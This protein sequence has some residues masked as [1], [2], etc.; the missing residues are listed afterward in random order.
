VS[1]AG[2]RSDVP[3]RAGSTFASLHNRNYRLFATSSLVANVGIWMQRV[4]QDWLLLVLT[5]SPSALGIAT[6]LQFLPMLLVS[7]FAGVVA[8]RYSKR[9]V[10]VVTQ[11]AMGLSSCFLGL[12][13]VTGSV[14]AW[15]V[16]A[17]ALVFG[18]GT[19][20]DRPTRQA[21]VNEV[22]DRDILVNAVGL[23][24]ASLNIGRAIGP[25]IAGLLIAWFGSG[26]ADT[27]AVILLNGISFF[28]VIVSLLRMRT[29][30]MVAVPPPARTERALREM[31]DGLNY[32]KARPDLMLVLTVT[33]IFGTF[34]MNFQLTTAL[35]STQVYDKGAAGFGI[36]GTILTIGSLTGSLTSARRSNVR[37]RTFILGA[38]ALGGLEIVAGLMP[39]YLSFA[40]ILPL[41]GFASMTTHVAAN[42]YVQMT[43]DAAVRGRVMA[44]F[45]AC[46]MGGTP[47]GAPVLGWV[48][49]QWGAR[50]TL[51]GGGAIT[52]ICTIIIAA[53]F[54]R[55]QNLD[56]GSRWRVR[57]DGAK[58]PIEV[59][60]SSSVA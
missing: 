41:C 20:F 58:A 3:T 2:A 53:A 43:S 18:I 19:A 56:V 54:A 12:L 39:T 48:A 8:D 25:A 21:Y 10:L 46:L 22:V 47:I 49:A 17:T 16:Y 32:V 59:V 30:D 31:R 11:A 9:R 36:L 15:H 55:R 27:G 60:D 5:D 44:L 50:W 57:E 40:L 14:T 45:L 6:G 29:A 52:A 24:S 42:T 23:N 26:I 37:M 1:L 35:M 34:G 28:I 7:P 4:S 38:V 51:I 13:A 33:F